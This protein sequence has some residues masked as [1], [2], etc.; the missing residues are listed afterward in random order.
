[1][2]YH[3]LGRGYFAFVLGN[4]NISGE[5]G[6]GDRRGVLN[7]PLWFQEIFRV[8]EFQKV[9]RAINIPQVCGNIAFSKQIVTFRKELGYGRLGVPGNISCQG[10]QESIPCHP[11]EP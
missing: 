8:E 4:I 10:I 11:K 3:S 6:V 5:G 9:F 7:P 1:M 2:K